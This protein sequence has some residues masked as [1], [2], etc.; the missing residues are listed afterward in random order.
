MNGQGGLQEA[1]GTDRHTE[2]TAWD[3]P[4]S[5]P[6]LLL[7]LPDGPKTKAQQVS[8]SQNNG[9]TGARPHSLTQSKP[10][11]QEETK[12]EG[13][14]L[15]ALEGMKRFFVFITV[16]ALQ[17]SR[18]GLSVYYAIVAIKCVKRSNFTVHELGGTLGQTIT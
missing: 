1:S 6:P 13:W 7:V 12:G 14:R 3:S 9:M 8:R 16:R 2:F 4:S 11:N 18:G 10:W 15:E 5:V 17:E